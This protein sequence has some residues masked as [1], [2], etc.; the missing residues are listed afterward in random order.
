MDLY[1]RQLWTDQRLQFP[2]DVVDELSLNS[3][4][5]DK[6]WVPDTYFVNEKSAKF[7]DVI[8]KNTLIRIRQNGDIL[9]STR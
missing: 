9:Y 1:F 3:E 7:H 6:L 2:G 8:Y 5:V 4:M